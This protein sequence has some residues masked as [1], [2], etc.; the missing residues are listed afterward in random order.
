MLEITTK[1][2]KK[3][4]ELTDSDESVI[5]DGKRF[6]LEDVYNS[7][8]LMQKFNTQIK[9]SDKDGQSNETKSV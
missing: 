2:G 5:I 8:D 7:D 3:I 1:T 9:S 4:A 6:K